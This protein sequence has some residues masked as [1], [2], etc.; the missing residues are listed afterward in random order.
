MESHHINHANSKLNIRPN[1]SE[2]GIETRYLNEILIKKASIYARS[3]NQNK[4]KYQTVFSAKIDEQDENDHMIDEIEYINLKNNQNLTGS[5]NNIIDIKS[6]LEQ[7]IQKQEMKESGWR[8]DKINSMTIY[9]YKTAEMN[10]SSYMKIP[11]RTSAI[12]KIENDDK[13]C[14]IWSISASLPPC[15]HSNPNRVSNYKEYFDELNIDGFDFSD[16]FKCS[17]VHIFET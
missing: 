12:L 9:F 5:D 1:Y 2:N 7:Q 15:E 13:Y 16:G 11:L 3:I 10:G 4:F 14:F 17:E 8:F 6:P